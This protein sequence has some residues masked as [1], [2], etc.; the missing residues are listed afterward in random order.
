MSSCKFYYLFHPILCIEIGIGLLV[1]IYAL[2]FIYSELKV[3]KH[4]R[5][6]LVVASIE[7]CIGMIAM[8]IGNGLTAAVLGIN[9][10]KLASCML[11]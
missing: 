7:Y 6:H 9:G 11:Y 8:G 2:Y 5:K 3:H 1:N 4:I 10:V